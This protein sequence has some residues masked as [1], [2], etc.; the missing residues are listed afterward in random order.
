MCLLSLPYP[1]TFIKEL[2][3]VIEA[4]MVFG[5]GVAGLLVLTHMHTPPWLTSLWQG[6]TT[7]ITHA[8]NTTLPTTLLLLTHFHFRVHS[9]GCSSSRREWLLILTRRTS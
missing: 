9:V 2:L 1:T 4:V 3:L 6:K 8:G 7:V 5:S